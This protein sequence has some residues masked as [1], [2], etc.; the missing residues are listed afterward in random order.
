MQHPW[1]RSAVVYQVYPRSFVDS[2]GDGVGDLPGVISKVPYLAETLGVDA[3]W[4]SPFYPSP[5]ADFGYDVADFC[6]VDPRFGSLADFDALVAACGTAGLAV[7][8]DL[9]P[10]HTSDEH[11]W[12]VESR[13]ARTSPRR[14]WYVWRDPAPDGGPPNNWLSVFGGPAWRLDDRTGQYYLHTF[15]PKQPDLNWRHP[16]VRAA[17]A[18]VVR[19][20][21]DRGAAG[22]RI[23]V[24]HVIGKDPELADD[25]PATEGWGGVGAHLGDFAG[26]HHV[27]S[28]GHP[29]AH[30]WYRDLRAVLDEYDEAY[31]IGEIHEPD[32]PRLVAWLGDGDELHQVFDFSL[33]HAPWD[34]DTIGDR[35][36]A[37]ESALPEWAWPNHV[38]GN[39]DEPRLATRIGSEAARVAAVLLLTTRG[40][41]TIY[42][43]D[44]LGMV[45][46]DI[47]LED[48]LDP[49]AG[50]GSYGRDSCRTPMP[51]SSGPHAGF[52]PPG[53]EATWLAVAADA[54]RINVEAQL[55]DDDS[56]LALY[57]RLLALRRSEPALRLG[58]QRRLVGLPEGV[59]GYERILDD[60]RLVVLASF[61]D[62]PADVT[63]EGRW[64]VAAATSGGLEGA[65]HDGNVPQPGQAAQVLRPA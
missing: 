20:W 14:D 63:L 2:D 13:A 59:L 15:D 56:M 64:S 25:P 3:V 44:E 21:L 38:L 57:R 58:D 62:E 43:G 32:W 9:V 1:W 28:L 51:W 29:D 7:I 31:S 40:T 65:I 18:D 17:M 26:L 11:P 19:F 41:P 30:A 53:T 33:L 39:H 50:P 42:Q 34:A 54:D 22:F 16:A 46:A 52:S 55:A 60:D 36:D 12:F 24:A 45:D 5:Q 27:H 48:Q 37:Q 47:P 23:D 8:V 61:V 35:I 49:Q 6:D 4:L 10:N